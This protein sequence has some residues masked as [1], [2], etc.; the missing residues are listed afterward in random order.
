MDVLINKLLHVAI[1]RRWWLLVH[2]VVVALCA[3]A[4][5]MVLPN[6]Y[7]SVA[8]ILVA[9]QQVPERYVTPNSTSNIRE[10]L[11][12]MTEEILSRT[13]LLRIIDEFDLYT[14]DRKHLAAEDL[15]ELLRGDIKIQPL[16]KGS[17]AA[18]LNSFAIAYTSTDPHL[19]QEVTRKLT[20]L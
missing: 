17:E 14:K 8:T 13:Q 1:K 9:H 6:H 4:T 16:E 15:V 20:T 5:S 3:C 2:T 11:L 7:V 18:D 19:A 10:Q 12:L